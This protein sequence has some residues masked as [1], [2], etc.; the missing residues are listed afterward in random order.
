M[1]EEK[2]FN[3]MIACSKKLVKFFHFI[4]VCFKRLL[5]ITFAL[6]IGTAMLSAYTL[7]DFVNSV[8]ESYKGN[9]GAWSAILI[10]LLIVP[11]ISYVLEKGLSS[12]LEHK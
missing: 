12:Y 5:I 10:I 7:I 11:T 6:A 8:A 3:M 9:P 4:V 1:E 2:R